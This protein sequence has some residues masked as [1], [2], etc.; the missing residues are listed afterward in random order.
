[1]I[2]IVPLM[3]GSG[4]CKTIFIFGVILFL[5]PLAF[6]GVGA[7]IQR[8]EDKGR[9][10][11]DRKKCPWNEAVWYTSW[12]SKWSK[13]KLVTWAVLT[14]LI[15]GIYFGLVVIYERSYE[16][17]ETLEE[18]LEQLKCL[19][20]NCTAPSWRIDAYIYTEYIRNVTRA[21]VQEEVAEGEKKS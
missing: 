18:G 11:D 10:I 17:K 4:F 14:V 2:S 15:L 1:V 21:V 7:L 8:F 13:M 16:T 20:F 6:N 9:G 3:T 5:I 12:K 19:G